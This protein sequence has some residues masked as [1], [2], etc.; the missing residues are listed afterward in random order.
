MSIN[1][2]TEDFEHEINEMVIGGASYLDAVTEWCTKRRLEP[3]V[4]AELVLR[5]PQIQMRL[6]MEAEGLALVKHRQ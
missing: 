6:Q 3:E 2:N 1:I 5:H 4:G